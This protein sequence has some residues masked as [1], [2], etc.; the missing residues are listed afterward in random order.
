LR[1]NPI[2]TFSFALNA[3]PLKAGNWLAV[4]RIRIRCFFWLD[5]VVGAFF[6]DKRAIEALRRSWW[7][8]GRGKAGMLTFPIE[9]SIAYLRFFS[10]KPAQRY[11]KR[12]K[13]LKEKL[14][15]RTWTTRGVTRKRTAKTVEDQFA[16]APEHKTVQ[17]ILDGKW[18]SKE[19]L[20][21]LIEA[22]NMARGKG[23]KTIRFEDIP[24]IEEFLVAEV[25]N[26]TLGSQGRAG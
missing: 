8:G 21:N 3:W 14:A 6:R 4:P 12:A 11:P 25:G 7:I 23:L 9:A 22:L 2:R 26:P 16:G 24:E 18:V 13:W 20:L 19:I 17:R 5:D 15:E 10:T 1:L